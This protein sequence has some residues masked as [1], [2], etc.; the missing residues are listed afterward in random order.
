M[1]KKAKKIKFSFEEEELLI[2]FVKS[3]EVLYN[4]KH[5]AF[6]D[7]EAKNRLWMKFAEQLDKDGEYS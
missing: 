4:V 3:H 2:D 7:T 1:S 6:R 5:K